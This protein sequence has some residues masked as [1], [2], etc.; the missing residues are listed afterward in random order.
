M[1]SIIVLQARTGSNRLPAKALLPVAGIP[2]A[3]LSAKRAGNTGRKVI[4]ATSNEIQDD[5]LASTLKRFGLPYFRGSLNNTLDRVTRAT[6]NYPDDTVFIRLTADNIFPDGSL[7]DAIEI[8]FLERNLN[9]ITCNGETSGL[10]HGVSVEMTFIKHLRQANAQSTSDNDR[11]HVTPYIIR[12]FG[13]NV[14]TKYK[15]TKKEHL[16]CTVD[17]YE[18]YIEVCRVFNGIRDPIKISCLELINKLNNGLH[19]AT[20][21]TLAPKLVLGAA[22]IGMVYGITNTVGQPSK[23]DA[24]K[25]IK[26]AIINGVEFI[27]TAQVYGNS[28]A[29]IGQALDTAVWKNRVNI[30]TNLPPFTDIPENASNALIN[31]KVDASIFDSCRKLCTSTLSTILLH[32]SLIHI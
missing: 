11:E 25:I 17:I 28:E 29:V 13:K 22:Q 26:T 18:D 10:P 32:L 5:E 16:R 12:Q 3:V 2:L 8:D 1:N 19:Q 9:Y 27:D 6:I 15:H 20:Q 23:Q 24:E 31:A 4:V 21:T 30:I 14:F 7:I